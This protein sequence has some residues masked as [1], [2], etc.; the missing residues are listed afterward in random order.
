[1]SFDRSSLKALVVRGSALAIVGYGGVQA[2]RLIRS[3]ILTRL[4]FPEVFGLMSLVWVVM[5]GLEMLSDVGLGPAIMRHKRGDDPDFLNTAWTMQA[6]RGAA[7]WVASCVVALPMAAFYGASDLAQL[8]PVAGLTALIGGFY[9]TALYTCRRRMEFG[10]LTVLELSNEIVA[11]VVTILWVYFA[12]NVW[13][14]V[15]GALISR[16]L[17]TIASHVAL[18][19]IQNRFRWDYSSVRELVGFGKWIFFSSAF[20]FLSTQSDRMLLGYYLNMALLG[21]Y[22]IAVMLSEAVQALVIKINYGVLFPAYGNVLLKDPDRLRFVYYRARLGTDVLL[23]LPIAVLMILGTRVVELLYDA[24]Y[25]DAGWMLQVLCVRLLMTSA[26]SNSE[27]CLVVLGQPQYAVIQNVCRTVWTLVG[28]PVGWH[29]MGLKGA[30][31]AVALSEVP[32]VVVLW[33]GLARN[34]VLSVRSELRS[35]FFAGIGASLGF[36]LQLILP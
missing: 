29:L 26:L 19:G 24:R 10:R 5:Y 18:P 23:I 15:G 36:G 9:S 32:V 33:I 3:L 13:A 22:S 4:L 34:H 21:T 1:M 28:I 14:L 7:L 6:I 31:W 11:F 25:H 27:S 30:V 12:P 8:I 16:L 17:F 35:L 20:Q 2:I